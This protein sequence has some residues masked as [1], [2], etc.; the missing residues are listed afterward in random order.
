MVQV[1]TITELVLIRQLQFESSCSF[2]LPLQS[3]SCVFS[4]SFNEYVGFRRH[5]GGI[6]GFMR[7]R[8]FFLML[9]SSLSIS[10]VSASRILT[11]ERKLLLSI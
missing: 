7:S 3:I 5:E 1:S 8:H 2:V 10:D 11:K 6:I 9:P 4:I